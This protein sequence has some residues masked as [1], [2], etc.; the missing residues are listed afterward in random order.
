LYGIEKG[1]SQEREIY[2]FK[3]EDRVGITKQRGRGGPKIEPISG[4]D[5]PTVS[6]Q[7]CGEKE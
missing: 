4:A 3:H 7:Q 5:E 2:E 6:R 1:W